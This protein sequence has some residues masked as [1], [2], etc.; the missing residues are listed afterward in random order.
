MR[1]DKLTI[2]VRCLG[3]ATVGL[4]VAA[5]VTPSSIRI[6]ASESGSGTTKIN[7]CALEVRPA[8]IPRCDETRDIGCFTLSGGTLSF[9]GVWLFELDGHGP[10]DDFM[11]LSD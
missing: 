7:G 3:R 9:E 1:S 10:N 5:K 8:T 4:E 11:K 6:L 2:A